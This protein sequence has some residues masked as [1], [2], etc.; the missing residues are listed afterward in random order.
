[1]L[2]VEKA[3]RMEAERWHCSAETLRT[4][5]SRNTGS[6]NPNLKWRCMRSACPMSHP[7]HDSASTPLCGAHR[8]ANAQVAFC[9]PQCVC[10]AAKG[11]AAAHARMRS[12]CAALRLRVPLKVRWPRAPDNT[13]HANAGSTPA[14]ASAIPMTWRFSRATPVTDS[15]TWQASSTTNTPI[16]TRPRSPV[17]THGR[18]R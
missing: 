12:G 3:S 1:M 11:G 2:K 16:R 13:Q 18:P 5:V 7:R 17:G 9:R 4:I 8:M 14:R 15:P 10:C 6:I